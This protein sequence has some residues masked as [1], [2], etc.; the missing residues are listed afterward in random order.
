MVGF[1]QPIPWIAS[2]N[3]KIVA[4][5]AA[6]FPFAIGVPFRCLEDDLVRLSAMVLDTCFKQSLLLLFFI[7]L[8]MSLC[9]RFIV[10][11]MDSM[12]ALAG[13]V[14]MQA[15]IEIVNRGTLIVQMRFQ[16]WMRGFS[17][18]ETNEYLESSQGKRYLA[19]VIIARSFAE[20]V[21]FLLQWI[22]IAFYWE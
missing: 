12:G 14:V 15:I 6:V 11:S 7:A 22:S 10:T 19:S 17:S 3:D 13:T 1:P 20:Y 21:A 9:A 8:L 4:I 16:R 18:K 5:I 2:Q